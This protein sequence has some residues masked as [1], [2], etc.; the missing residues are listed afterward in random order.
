MYQ[1]SGTFRLGTSVKSWFMKILNTF[2][3]H[4]NRSK[5][6][7]C[8]LEVFNHITRFPIVFLN[9]SL[10]EYSEMKIMILMICSILAIMLLRF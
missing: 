9:N 2:C 1:I 7:K 6:Q 5:E 8:H 4:F 10:V 3:L